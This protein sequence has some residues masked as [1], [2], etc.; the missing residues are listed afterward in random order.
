MNNHNKYALITGGT[1]DI[2][3]EIAKQFA[4]HGYNLVIVARKKERLDDVLTEFRNKFNVDVITIVKDLFSGRPQK[5]F[6]MR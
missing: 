1:S 6:M 5:K 4:K 3:Y 2:G